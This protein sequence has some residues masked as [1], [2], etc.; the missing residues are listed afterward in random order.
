LLAR[1]GQL[2]AWRVLAW[3]ALAL[4]APMQALPKQAL[5]RLRP[6]LRRLVQLVVFALLQSMQ[7]T[8]SLRQESSP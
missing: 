6:A 8:M 5:Q 3:G 4:P 1:V 7:C 2:L